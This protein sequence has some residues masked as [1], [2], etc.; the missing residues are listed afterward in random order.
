MSPRAASPYGGTYP[1]WFEACTRQLIRH[2]DAYG[3]PYWTRRRKR[4]LPH[5]PEASVDF[6][7][8]S[9]FLLDLDAEEATTVRPFR[10]SDEQQMRDEWRLRSERAVAGAQAKKIR[11]QIYRSRESLYKTALQ[12]PPLWRITPHDILSAALLGRPTSDEAAS[13]EAEGN[14][15]RSL[16]ISLCDAH[17]IP[18]QAL[19]NDDDLLRWLLLRRRVS[20]KSKRQVA[21]SVIL[22]RQ[23]AYNLRQSNSMA[24]VR[25]LMYLSL[26]SH[27]QIGDFGQG[28]TSRSA[29]VSLT[30][31]ACDRALASSG[32][33]RSTML[34]T[35]TFLGNL[36]QASYR[37]QRPIGSPLVGLALRL[38]AQLGE[39]EAVS[40]WLQRFCQLRAW[41]DR[42]TGKDVTATLDALT[43]L[44][45]DSADKGGI[46]GPER[47]AVL[48]QVLV[49]LQERDRIDSDSVRGVLLTYMDEGMRGNRPFGVYTMYGAY[50]ELL[51]RL[52]AGRLLW[53]EWRTSGPLARRMW[54]DKDKSASWGDDMVK[55]SFG[56]AKGVEDCAWLDYDDLVAKAT[57]WHGGWKRPLESIG[58]ESQDV[59][60]G[61]LELPLYGFLRGVQQLRGGGRG[62][63]IAAGVKEQEQKE[64]EQEK[65]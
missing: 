43:G 64:Q 35:L 1:G 32:G 30:R 23:V 38:S 36:W 55:Q 39:L 54:E 56:R 9:D 22:P 57:R 41:E 60:Q 8:V 4:V 16:L 17:G 10:A 6:F 7:K 27:N 11:D 53:C 24:L 31:Q 52:G 29:V 45:S 25:R 50:L 48:L 18:P 58:P 42:K 44:V 65:E 61:L 62:G 37:T 34:E 59:V 2:V 33:S 46:R 12:T 13:P 19:I 15:D 51:G 14:K 26:S 63:G 47:R 21:E 5:D 3:I 28:Q 40:E 49:G 20:E